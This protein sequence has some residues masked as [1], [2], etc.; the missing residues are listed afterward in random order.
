MLQKCVCIYIRK[1]ITFTCL[2]FG[3]IATMYNRA[4]YIIN[5]K[6][7]G[8][9]LFRAKKTPCRTQRPLDGQYYCALHSNIE[10]LWIILKGCATY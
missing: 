7:F 4:L 2:I 8:A 9:T 3:I 6:R 1:L 5:N 10:H